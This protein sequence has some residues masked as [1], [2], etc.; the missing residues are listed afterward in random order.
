LSQLIVWAHVT[1]GEVSIIVDPLM[2]VSILL[3]GGESHGVELHKT[4][5]LQ[6]DVIQT[7][8]PMSLF[9]KEVISKSNKK[10]KINS[11][12][13]RSSNSF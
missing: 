1:A 2:C 7:Y 9:R 5:Y 6:Y 11:I 4:G 13:G 8:V 10:K 12:R 3:L